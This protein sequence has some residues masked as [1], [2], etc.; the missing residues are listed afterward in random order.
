MK[1]FIDIILIAAAISLQVYF[2]DN[3]TD[4]R[5]PEDRIVSRIFGW[6]FVILLTIFIALMGGVIGVHVWQR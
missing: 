4:S 3:A 1:I 2:I 5:A 6:I